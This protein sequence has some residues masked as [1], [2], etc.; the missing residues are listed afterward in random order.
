MIVL[1]DIARGV[2]DMIAAIMGGDTERV[3]DA[4]KIKIM[5]AIYTQLRLPPKQSWLSRDAHF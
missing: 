1:K 4:R 2:E 5:G 3:R